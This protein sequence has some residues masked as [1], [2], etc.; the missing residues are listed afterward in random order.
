MSQK[1]QE[2]ISALETRINELEEENKLLKSRTGELI[3]LCE[4]SE[5]NR[6]DL[7]EVTSIHPHNQLG[8]RRN[9]KNYRDFPT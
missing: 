8:T 3:S 7:L 2:R 6:F 4:T 1:Q 5:K 9:E